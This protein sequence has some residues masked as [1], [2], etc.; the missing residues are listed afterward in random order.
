MKTMKKYII[1]YELRGKRHLDVIEGY[2]MNISRNVWS[3]LLKEI[4]DT[5]RFLSISELGNKNIEKLKKY[6]N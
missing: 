3:N 5:F 1:T 4:S 2:N 6:Y